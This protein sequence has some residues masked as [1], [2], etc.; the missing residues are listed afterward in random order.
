MG[1]S[2]ETYGSLLTPIILNK[3]P[4][5]IK[6]HL[7]R[8]NNSAEWTLDTLMANILREFRVFETSFHN[9]GAYD[10]GFPTPNEPL[11]ATASFHTGT[12]GQSNRTTE[13]KKTACVFCKGPY[14][15]NACNTVTKPEER[16]SLVKEN[17]LCFNCLARHKVSQCSSK[18]RCRKCARKHHTSLC[19]STPR[20]G[21]HRTIL[22]MNQ[23]MM[24]QRQY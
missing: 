17:R 24:T 18:F 22:R 4:D 7:A 21:E 10:S 1:K 14:S 2:P 15:S 16:M 9:V 12:R 13:R 11:L 6:K 20:Q 23:Q 19:T 5:E 8:E 3:L